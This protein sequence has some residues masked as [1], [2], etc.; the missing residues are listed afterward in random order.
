MPEYISR[1][2]FHGTVHDLL[3]LAYA[4]H[5]RHD[6][7]IMWMHHVMG[8]AWLLRD[9]W[10]TDMQAIMRECGAELSRIIVGGWQ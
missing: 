1:E 4:P 10:D 8:L 6:D 7:R 5:A 2:E 9:V 3:S